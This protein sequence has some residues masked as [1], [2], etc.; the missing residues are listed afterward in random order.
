MPNSISPYS[1][2]TPW[3]RQNEAQRL[4]NSKGKKKSRVDL[5]SLFKQR[6]VPAKEREEAINKIWDSSEDMP[7][8]E[9]KEERYIGVPES[10]DITNR[11]H[12]ALAD[13][14]IHKIKKG[15]NKPG[16]ARRWYAVNV[17]IGN[18]K[19]I[20][21]NI[22]SLSER[23]GVSKEEIK[24]NEQLGTVDQLIYDK[25]LDVE[26]GQEAVEKVIKKIIQLDN[27]NFE[28]NLEDKKKF[29]YF[30][31]NH[32]NDPWLKNNIETF[33]ENLEASETFE[34]DKDKFMIRLKTKI[35]WESDLEG[36]TSEKIAID[37]VFTSDKVYYGKAQK[38]IGHKDKESKR[39]RFM[40]P[41]KNDRYAIEVGDFVYKKMPRIKLSSNY[42][43]Y[44]VKLEDGEKVYILVNKQSVRR[45]GRDL[46]HFPPKEGELEK[47]VEEIKAF[48][49]KVEKCNNSEMLNKIITD[50]TLA[51]NKNGQLDY[52]LEPRGHPDHQVNQYLIHLDNRTERTPQQI[53][54]F[55]Q[56]LRDLGALDPLVKNKLKTNGNDLVE[57]GRPG[58]KMKIWR[59]I[60]LNNN[61]NRYRFGVGKYTYE[62]GKPLRYSKD[63]VPYKMKL[64]DGEEV[65]EVYILL[66]IPDLCE[67]L[68]LKRKEIL[69]ANKNGQL[70][71]LID[72]KVK[73]IKELYEKILKLEKNTE[74]RS[75]L[76]S[77]K[78]GI[79]FLNVVNEVVFDKE[80]VCIYP[81]K[82]VGDY[83]KELIKFLEDPETEEYHVYVRSQIRDRLQ[84]MGAIGPRK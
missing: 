63:S 25:L 49:E 8:P 4:P 80:G 54:E 55:K 52:R 24:K 77:E 20:T 34:G 50:Y 70:E 53:N 68:G 66:N 26:H 51:R 28:L 71:E 29:I 33:M 32:L 31:K 61:R 59:P 15:L 47:M 41:D 7:I 44:P 43:P 69:E 3:A 18:S 6:E 60:I 35:W 27:P 9:S 78:R 46:D 84:G 45:L 74:Y 42:F 19:Y 40:E 76:S 17:K 14:K 64:K 13:K 22:N 36:V 48:R 72:G 65:R 2:N 57:V 10:R 62:G 23:L 82:E 39:Y 81:D 1:F 79:S 67:R 30:I 21:L 5:Y 56:K 73:K 38:I 11:L 12:I 16:K 58:K 75:G 37:K 83:L